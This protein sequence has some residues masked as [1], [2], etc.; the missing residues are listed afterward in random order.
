MYAT[1]GL[2]PRQELQPTAESDDRKGWAA[3]R[4]PGWR[5]FYCHDRETF[6][7]ALRRGEEARAERTDVGANNIDNVEVTADDGNGGTTMQ[8]I[9]VTVTDANDAP[10]F[11]S[12]ASANFAEN[13]S[14]ETAINSLTATDADLPIKSLRS[15]KG[16]GQTT[17]ALNWRSGRRLKIARKSERRLTCDRLTLNIS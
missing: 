5:P 9:A 1:A 3:K 11:T 12:S 6:G 8:A 15:A 16:A 13:T 14:A 17:L 7:R 2:L 4:G 10:A